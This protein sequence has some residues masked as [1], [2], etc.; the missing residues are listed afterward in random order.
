MAATKKALGVYTLEEAYE[1][2]LHVRAMN[3][4]MRIA[5]ELAPKTGD[6]GRPRW[7]GKPAA[8]H[9][10]TLA[11]GAELPAAGPVAPGAWGLGGLGAWGRATTVE[12][13]ATTRTT[14]PTRGAIAHG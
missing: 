3:T 13:H 4:R 8:A 2:A 5:R 7:G 11:G 6:A 14:A 1:A 12:R 9:V 10:A